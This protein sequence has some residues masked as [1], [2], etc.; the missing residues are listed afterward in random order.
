MG[1]QEKNKVVPIRPPIKELSSTSNQISIAL[2]KCLDVVSLQENNGPTLFDQNTKVA[3]KF[4]IGELT[5]ILNLVGNCK[6]IK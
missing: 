2:K 5:K 1:T 6:C 4:I 3:V